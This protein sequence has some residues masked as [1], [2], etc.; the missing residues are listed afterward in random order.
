[1]TTL[2]TPQ[3]IEGPSTPAIASASTTSV[4]LPSPPA[5]VTQPFRP[6]SS[7]VRLPAEA[8]KSHASSSRSTSKREAPDRKPKS[9]TSVE[10][11]RSSQASATEV[12]V[13]VIVFDYQ[14]QA[15]E[16]MAA[17]STQ[18]GELIQEYARKNG[19]NAKNI[20]YESLASGAYLLGSN[21]VVPTALSGH[22]W[23]PFSSV[24]GPSLYSKPKAGMIRSTVRSRITS[25]TTTIAQHG[26]LSSFV[27]Q[28]AE[29]CSVFDPERPFES[30]RFVTSIT[31]IASRTSTSVAYAHEAPNVDSSMLASRK[32][33]KSKVSGANWP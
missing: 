29:R 4:R 22:A 15:T 6:P 3:D 28:P 24:T 27:C 23:D 17:R 19:L 10:G 25:R 20:T 18:I 14:K 32:G 9:V 2:Q 31:H 26:D 11:S 30:S 12:K 21:M 7:V 1:M 5:S 8:A 13:D 33:A 16:I